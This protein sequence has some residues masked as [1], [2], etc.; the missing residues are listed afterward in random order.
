LPSG[1]ARVASEGASV[2]VCSPVVDYGADAQLQ[3]AAELDLLP[4]GTAVEALLADYA[5]M[6]GQARA[7][8]TGLSH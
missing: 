2:A 8:A 7:C 4:D 5:V 3:A 6:R 1:C